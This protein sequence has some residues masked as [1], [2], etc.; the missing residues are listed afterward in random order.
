MNHN[1]GNISLQ[2]KLDRIVSWGQQA[3]DL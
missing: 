2:S 3:I 1:N